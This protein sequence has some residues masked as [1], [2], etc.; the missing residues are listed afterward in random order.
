MAKSIT[1]EIIKFKSVRLSFAQ[2]DK[3]KAFKPGQDPRFEA[4]FLL[5]PS[6]EEHKT[7][8]RTLMAEADKLVKLKW[9]NDADLKDNKP[10]GLQLCF[11]L[12]NKNP[13]KAKYDGY[14]DMFYVVTANKDRPTIVTRDREAVVPG[15]KQWPYSGCYVNTNPTLWVQDNGFG[16]AIRANLRIVQFVDDGKP[17]GAGS[18]NADDEFEKLPPK[19]SQGVSEVDDIDL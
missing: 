1:S 5:D 11:G 14:K 15:H 2:L 8:I 17:F 6:S 3:P 12:A 10:E 19:G 9:G 4:T 18:A 16:I 13:K 7:Q